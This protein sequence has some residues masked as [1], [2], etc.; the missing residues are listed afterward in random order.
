MTTKERSLLRSYAQTIEPIGQI[1][2]G[3]ISE[4]MVTGISD[5]LDK[6]EIVKL[7]VLRNSDDDAKDLAEDL[8]KRLNAQVVCT[9]GHKIILYRLSDRKGIKHILP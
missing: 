1:G 9:I 8:A 2:K 7:S 6:R 4:S 3:G 5:A